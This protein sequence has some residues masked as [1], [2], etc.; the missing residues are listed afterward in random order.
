MRAKP[1]ADEPATMTPNPV[2]PAELS[3]AHETREYRASPV[4][5]LNGVPRSGRIFVNRNLRLN[6]IAAIGFDLD[7]TLA[8]YRIKE[9]DELA[10][11]ITQEKLVQQLGY[12]REILE[13]DFDANFVARGL[14][15]DKRRGNIL[16]MDYHNYVVRACHGLTPLDSAERK[17]VYRMRRIRVSNSNYVSVDTLFHVPEAYLVL[18]VI[19]LLEG[20]GQKVDAR[21]LADDVRAMIDEAHADGSIKLKIEKN[22]ARY[23]HR[24]PRLPEVLELFRRGGKKLFLLTNSERHYTDVL[25]RHLFDDPDGTRWRKAFDFVVVEARKP[26]FFR[27]H[28]HSGDFVDTSGPGAPL[29]AGGDVWTLEKHLGHAGDEILYWGDHT[30]GDILRSKKT[31]G[32]RTAMIIPELERELDISDHVGSELSKLTSFLRERDLL[33][34]EETMTRVEIGRLESMHDQIN[35]TSH[36]ARGS[37]ARKVA[38]AKHRLD[39]LV[40]AR[41]KIHDVIAAQDRA[42]SDMYNPWWGPLFREGN[43]ISRFGHQVKDFACVYTSRVSNFLNYPVNTYFRAPLEKMS[44]EL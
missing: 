13:I 40:A 34:Q 16:K 29:F 2:R 38:V 39:E 15:L 44:H 35:E 11:R 6:S 36:E 28:T 43:E 1:R 21:K 12:P 41:A 42:C 23:I 19:S 4:L 7:Y 31:V 33:D 30:Y 26:K 17:R 24:D 14:L 18:S 22:P 27:R 25:F 20:R 3:R 10:F 37:L 5:P 8:H 32:W 9:V